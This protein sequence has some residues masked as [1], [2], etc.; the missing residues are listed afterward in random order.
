MDKPTAILPNASQVPVELR[1]LPRW[2][3]FRFTWDDSKEK[4]KKPP[5]SP[6]DGSPIGAVEK[7]AE[8][9]LTFDKA[10]AGAKQHQLDGVGFV[11]VAG[12]GY[13]GI[14]FDDCRTLDGIIHP[15]VKSLLR[16]FPSYSEVSPSGTGIHVIARGAIAKA[17]TATRLS[18][19][20]N[21]TVEAYF[22]GRYF[23][24]TGQRIADHNHNTI[25][26]CQTA[27]HKWLLPHLQVKEPPASGTAT[28]TEQSWT[29]EAIRALYEKKLDEL[30]HAPQGAGNA[31]LNTVALIAARISASKVF[32]K[33][34]QQFRHELLDIVTREWASPHPEHG[35]K[36]TILSGWAKGAKEGPFHLI[37][38]LSPQE[39]KRPDMPASVLCG[40]LGEICRTR[41]A[42]FPI[43]YSWPAVLGAASVLVKSQQSRC[44]IFVA[45]VGDVHTGKSQVIERVTYLFRL[46]EQGLLLEGKYG[47]AEGLLE[48][49]GDRQGAPV[50]WAPDELSHVLE[51]AQIQGASFPF[52]LNTV[53]YKD[54]NVLTVMH[55]KK[56]SFNARLSILG[57]VVE[58]NFG[59]SFGAATTAGLYDRFLFGLF[60]TGSFEY[61]YRPMQGPPL[62]ELCGKGETLFGG[63]TT[64]IE[65]PK[66]SA[67]EIDKSVWEARDAIRKAEG[68]DSRILELA[69]RVAMVCAAWDKRDVLRASDLEPAWELARYQHRVRGM[70]QP[71]PGRNFEAMAAHKIMAYLKQHAD[72]E[73]WLAWR[74]VLRA[75][76]VMEFGLS[77]ANRALD[78]L[79]FAG[80]IEE[81]SIPR[82][83]GKGR[84][85]WVVRL[86][87]ES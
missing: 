5:H 46:K 86:S 1:E 67:P 70:L 74:D 58:K 26:D 62:F 69:I 30:R 71:N 84:K 11:F 53:F 10:V 32:E 87:K 82:P 19:N 8:H 27:I 51:K 49:V 28:Q 6:V 20:S 7:Y 37:E 59:D 75:T 43:A 40:R 4:W 52:I 15:D 72:G 57:G 48:Q 18:E 64:V 35:A 34:D 78:A 56:I 41:L 25:N 9:W 23:T 13:V 66:V 68:I 73:K 76:H 79:V 38:I 63:G 3:G 21:A 16:W 17:L 42:D 65:G 29:A 61:S 81:A 2:C 39:I 12:D 50:L 44:N 14:D 31:M 80:E 77:V 33:T 54:E 36:Q 83:D 55:R 24:F 22:T 60:P 85:K 45:P 47:S